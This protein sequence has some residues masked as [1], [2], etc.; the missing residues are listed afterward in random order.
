MCILSKGSLIVFLLQQVFHTAKTQQLAL[1]I[2]LEITQANIHF[3]KKKKQTVNELSCATFGRICEKGNAPFDQR[4]LE[5][6]LSVAR[7]CTAT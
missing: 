2:G 6:S 4:S 3:F 7:G 5:Q 1:T